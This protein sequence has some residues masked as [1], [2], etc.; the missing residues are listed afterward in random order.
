MSDTSVHPKQGRLHFIVE[1]QRRT[2]TH[3]KKKD[4]LKIMKGLKEG[5]RSKET[6][7]TTFISSEA[8]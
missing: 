6:R 4:E 2:R 8:F 5:D 7:M 3:I 1:S